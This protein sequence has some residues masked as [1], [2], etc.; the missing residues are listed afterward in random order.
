[1]TCP[2]VA[3]A[4]P[5]SSSPA[6]VDD[7]LELVLA[8]DDLVAAEFDEIVGRAWAGEVEPTEPSTRREVDGP[9]R[10]PICGAPHPAPDR[11]PARPPGPRVRSPPR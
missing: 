1:M 2:L 5:R 8:D 9:S 3:D 10:G 11:V 7:F 4:T 6:V